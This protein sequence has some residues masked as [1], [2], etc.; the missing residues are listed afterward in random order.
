MLPAFYLMIMMVAA[1]KAN[2]NGV[3]FWTAYFFNRALIRLLYPTTIMA[4]GARIFSPCVVPPNKKLLMKPFLFI[5][6]TISF[7]KPVFSQYKIKDSCS[8][9][10]LKIEG[11]NLRSDTIRFDYRDCDKLNSLK[12]TLILSNGKATIEGTINRATE[13]ILYTNIRNR[14]ID[15]PGVIRFIL[16]PGNTN[17]SFTMTNDTVRKTFINGAAEKQKEMWEEDNASLLELRNGYRDKMIDSATEKEKQILNNKFDALT[18]LLIAN[19]LKYAGKNPKSYFSGYLLNYYQRRIPADTLV[20]YFCK[21]DS[22]V[23]YSDFGKYILDELFK[24]SDDWTFRE[25]FS[26]P[27][28]FKKLKN[29]KTIYDVSL[30]NPTGSETSFADFKGSYL[31][32]DFWASWCGPCVRNAPYLRQLIKEMKNKPIK[33]ISVS[34]DSDP[35]AWKKAIKKYEFP[36]T[37]LFDKYGLLST[38]Y[39]VLWVPRYIIV[40]PDG[41]IANSDAPQANDPELQS[42]LNSLLSGKK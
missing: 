12:D 36:G 26:D 10:S 8:T 35:E 17:L 32:I 37:H 28:S 34:I 20:S 16:E 25:K 4:N 15:G 29:I 3:K 21:L 19:I 9:F 41:T 18:E 1:L 24:L 38:F 40:T 22:A 7:C 11:I 31:L 5:F 6:L 42:I 2:C 13:A 33:F 27:E 30:T 23:I 14:W 39:K